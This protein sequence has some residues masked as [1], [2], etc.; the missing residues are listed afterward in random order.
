MVDRARWRRAQEYEADYWGGVADKQADLSWYEW[1]AN[2]LAGHLDEIGLSRLTDGESAVLE[3]GSGPVG[4]VSFFPGRHRVAVDPLA[5]EFTLRP[6]LVALRDESVR[7]LS[8]A[9]ERL[10]LRDD[11]FD[12]VVIE[13]CIDHVRDVDAVMQEIARV[14][15]PSGVLYLTVNCRS[16]WGVFAHGVLAK[17]R[18]DPG[19]PHSFSRRRL[20]RLLERHGF[21]VSDLAMGSLGRALW[22]DLTSGR[23]KNVA[24]ALLGVSYATARTVAR[25]ETA[26]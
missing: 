16:R 25:L 2:R 7:F 23:P 11:A 17:L 22:E 12:L 21:R 1:R 5:R 15:T 26:A 10:P 9:G 8:S 6:E 13:N 14:L 4:L 18:I 20:R 19:H 3:I 24:K